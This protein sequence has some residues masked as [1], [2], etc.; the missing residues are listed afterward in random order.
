MMDFRKKLDRGDRD[1]PLN[2][3]VVGIMS[4]LYPNVVWQGCI[5]AKIG[6]PKLTAIVRRLVATESLNWIHDHPN[7]A[8]QIRDIQT[9][10]FPDVS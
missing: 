5:K 3:G 9:F 10:Q 7:V 8:A 2:N 6:D 1:D 4:L